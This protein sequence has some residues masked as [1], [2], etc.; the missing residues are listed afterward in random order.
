MCK[1]VRLKRGLFA[2][3][4]PNDA[5]KFHPRTW[6]LDYAAMFVYLV[7][8][9][10]Y[11]TNAVIVFIRRPLTE[12]VAF[13]S[14]EEISQDTT[15]ATNKVTVDD[16][17]FRVGVSLQYYPRHSENIS[18]ARAFL[19]TK[20][21]AEQADAEVQIQ[22]LSF[23]EGGCVVDGVAYETPSRSSL[24]SNAIEP[25]EGG[26]TTAPIRPGADATKQSGFMCTSWTCP[27]S[28]TDLH[29]LIDRDKMKCNESH[30]SGRDSIPPGVSLLIW[31]PRQFDIRVSYYVAQLNALVSSENPTVC[32]D[33]SEVVQLQ[34]G[35]SFGE[36]KG[37]TRY[38]RLAEAVTKHNSDAG[39]EAVKV[40]R[41]VEQR[42]FT[43]QP[44]EGTYVAASVSPEDALYPS[45][46]FSLPPNA[47]VRDLF[48]FGCMLFDAGSAGHNVGLLHFS[49]G[50][51]ITVTYRTRTEDLWALLG[52][53]GGFS[54]VALLVVQLLRWPFLPK[55]EQKA[56]EESGNKVRPTG[57][58]DPEKGKSDCIIEPF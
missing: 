11:V 30:P 57:W 54:S 6:K 19:F 44:M 41:Q 4:L 18:H 49:L 32:E 45:V 5:L 8:M 14:L 55:V 42:S 17:S 46:N 16:V 40:W 51:T 10:V 50:N 35:V 53:I 48:P 21:N 24:P 37:H 7:I 29:D 36:I 28:D 27:Y 39:C 43:N 23:K 13:E 26:C 25:L 3:N 56:V 38:V 20:Y 15:A 47:Q 22:E 52:S 34:G 31:N 2:Y 58:E 9:A 33:T 12:R 1:G